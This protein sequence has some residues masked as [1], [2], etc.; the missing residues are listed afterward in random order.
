ML[1]V[2]LAIKTKRVFPAPMDVLLGFN[3]DSREWRY[4]NKGVHD[5]NDRAEFD[6]HTVEAVVATLEQLDAAL[7]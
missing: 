3:G 2:I 4:L 7:A 1:K 6:R 5:E